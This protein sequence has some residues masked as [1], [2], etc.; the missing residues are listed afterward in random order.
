M[1]RGTIWLMK[2]KTLDKETEQALGDVLDEL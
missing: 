2:F 1:G